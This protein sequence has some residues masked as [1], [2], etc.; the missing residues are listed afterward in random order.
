MPLI[1]HLQYYFNLD[2]LT[3]ILKNKSFKF[4]KSIVEISY[5]PKS[6][7]LQFPILF[8]RLHKYKLF[9]FGK[10]ILLKNFAPSS[11]IWL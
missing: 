5:K 11:S 2:I 1:L 10:F 3:I 8:H 9:R 4:D 6:P 7:I